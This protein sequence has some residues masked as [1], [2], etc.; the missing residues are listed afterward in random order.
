MKS[1]AKT[2][3]ALILIVLI[4]TG[5]F[6]APAVIGHSDKGP[7]DVLS[8]EYVNAPEGTFYADILV[9]KKKLG[10]EYTDFNGHLFTDAG[11]YTAI[12]EESDIVRYE[13][14]GYVSLSFHRSHTQTFIHEYVHR[15][16]ISAY[17]MDY[18]GDI[19]E[20]DAHLDAGQIYSKYGDIRLAYVDRD[21][22][23]LGVTERAKKKFILDGISIDGRSVFRAYGNDLTCET[24]QFPAPIQLII[25]VLL[26]GIP[27][28][29]IIL[30]GIIVTG[31]GK[32]ILNE[33]K[34]NR[35]YPGRDIL[36]GD[37]YDE[38][39]S[40]GEDIGSEDE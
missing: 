40:G 5:I 4:I 23:I 37:I 17:N 29:F 39:K 1:Y 11:A 20:V 6:L 9:R 32:F 16:D 10:D 18:P 33:I 13:E 34:R 35:Q 22:K 19:F 38:I 7:N 25:A 15:T 26:F 27:I 3:A 36:E 8:I 2:K 28:E 30:M 21:G 12:N 31:V 24:Y 14:D